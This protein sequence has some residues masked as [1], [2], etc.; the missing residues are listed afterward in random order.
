MNFYSDLGTRIELRWSRADRDPERFPELVAEELA[1]T[2][3]GSDVDAVTRSYLAPQQVATRQLGPPDAFAQPGLT[4]YYGR[5]FVIDIY[6]W[7]NAAPAIHNHP[8]TGCFTILKGFSLHDTYTFETRERA[9]E[10]VLL[11]ALEP[12]ELTILRAGDVVPFSLVEHPLIHS[13]VHVPVPTVS[14]VIRTILTRQY[15]R[16]FPPSIALAMDQ[17]DEPVA[18]QLQLIDWLRG[19]RDPSYPEQ[20]RALIASSDFETAF[21]II[22]AAWGQEDVDSLIACARRRH[23]DRVDLIEPGIREATRLQ[24]NNQWREQFG[25][26]DDRMIASILMCAHGRS[27]VFRL[28]GQ[29]FPDREPAV[30]L[31]DW[32]GCKDNGALSPNSIDELIGGT[33]LPRIWHDTIFHALTGE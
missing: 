1:K 9:G 4:L 20:V 27:D 17:P 7:L 33:A 15:F 8:F 12:N 16:Y 6:F 10:R 3:P 24:L 22:S 14:L 21:R 29:W 31:R 25:G 11:G 30:V 32:K 13:L 18:R 5:G 23:G 26:D 28:L 19:A 2:P